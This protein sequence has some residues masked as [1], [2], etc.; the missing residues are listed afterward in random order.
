MRNPRSITFNYKHI[1]DTFE[2]I[3][4]ID[5]TDYEPLKG[6]EGYM[7]NIKKGLVINPK[8]WILAEKPVKSGYHITQLPGRGTQ[9]VHRLVWKQKYG[10]IPKNY[11]VDHIDDNPGNNKIENLQLLTNAEN[12]A[13]AYK[14]GN[15]KKIKGIIMK[16]IQIIARN[17]DSKKEE[18]YSSISKASKALNIESSRISD[19]L[20][21]KGRTAINRE[22]VRYEFSY[23]SLP[24][25]VTAQVPVLTKSQLVLVPVSALEEQVPNLSLQE[26]PMKQRSVVDWLISCRR[27]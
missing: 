24:Q 22:N 5:L 19:I 26:K 9:S 25:V 17:Y 7:I 14:N 11:V 21:G 13:K 18:I 4:V 6:Q 3:E 8:R 2:R 1:M 23:F 12:V 20:R 27:L 10:A 16:A 15:T